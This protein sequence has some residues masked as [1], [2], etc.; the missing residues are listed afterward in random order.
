MSYRQAYISVIAASLA[1][2]T[3]AF[4]Q[5][6]PLP[7]GL[8]PTSDQKAEEK[9]ISA[10]ALPSGL[11]E[12]SEP[13]LPPG[14]G[15]TLTG[16][17]SQIAP[18]R[19]KDFTMP[20]GFT[21]FV[22]ARI[23]A[24]IVDDPTQKTLS[25]AE[26]RAQLERDVETDHATFR[27]VGD[28]LYD[29]VVDDH[30]IDLERGR[31][32]FDLREANVIVRPLDFL[33]IKAGRQILTWGVGDLYFINDLFAKDFQSF[34]IGRDDEY[35]KA[36]SDAVRISAFNKVANIE[37]VYMPRFDPDRSITG[38]RLSY[39]NPALGRIAGRDSLI[40][41]DI[42][43]RW[44]S[45]DEFAGR[46]YRQIGTFETAIYGYA[47]FWKTPEGLTT[48]GRPFHPRLAVFGAS[49]RGPLHGGL[50][51][52][53]VGHYLSRDDLTGANPLIRNSET[54]LLVGYEREIAKELTASVQYIAEVI[55]DFDALTGAAPIGS[56]TPDRVR[57]VITVRLTKMMLNQNLM[58]SVFN[59][60]S[61]SENDGYFRFRAS[62][63]LSDAWLAEGGGNVFYGAEDD[64][65]FGQF[66]NNTNIFVGLR[67]SF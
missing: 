41:A 55:S 24:R 51:T 37:F 48:T 54:R 10:P 12:P 43:D 19:A 3:L 67:R 23:G 53:E 27:F 18:D 1:T 66:E 30:S 36:P 61:P 9:D 57:H 25:I 2:M 32:F 21:G 65:F 52:A 56:P 62:Y 14:L 60:W 4:A 38:E 31:G 33:D 44:F 34:F 58:L 20:F 13:E 15:Q 11:G 47:G 6:P 26:I 46:A 28:F 64:T 29:S 8:S 49:L 22:E 35:L 50:V 16:E 7:A 17:P 42:P 45:D 59:F 5:D 39:F 63:K 40:D